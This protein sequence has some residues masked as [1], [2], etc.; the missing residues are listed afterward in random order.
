L[1]RARSIFSQVREMLRYE[2]ALFL[3]MLKPLMHIQ[4]PDWTTIPNCEFWWVRRLIYLKSGPCLETW[5]TSNISQI[6]DRDARH[7]R[8]RMPHISN[9]GGRQSTKLGRR[10]KHAFVTRPR[11]PRGRIEN[12]THGAH[13]S[14]LSDL[15]LKEET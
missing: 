10:S 7:H 6:L 15:M 9:H 4:A 2:K 1:L 13:L 3:L 11:S 5:S 14:K 12:L 8:M